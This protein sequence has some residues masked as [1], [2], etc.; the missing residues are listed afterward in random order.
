MHLVQQGGEAKTKTECGQVE[1]AFGHDRAN[2]QQD[3]GDGGQAEQS[4]GQAEAQTWLAVPGVYES[5]G[6][7]DEPQ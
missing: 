2:R 7:E 1:Q 3:I 4:P 5:E 6:E